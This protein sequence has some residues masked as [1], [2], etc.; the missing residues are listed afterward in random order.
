MVA[1][2]ADP[3]IAVQSVA[4]AEAYMDEILAKP[5]SGPGGTPGVRS[6]YATVGDYAGLSENPTDQF[7][8]PLGLNNY[9]VDVSVGGSD[10][11]IGAT[12]VEVSVTHVS[13]FSFRLR[14]HRVDF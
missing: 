13:G 10:L 11:G 14:G 2:S 6:S 5:V 8:N 12:E 3:L 9:T 4:I 1:R 7:G